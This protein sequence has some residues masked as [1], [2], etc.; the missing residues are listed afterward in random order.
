MNL[1]VLDTT[2]REGL[3]RVGTRLEP[4]VRRWVAEELVASG[5]AELEIGVVGRDGFL[6]A[7]LAGLQH[8]HPDHKIWVWTRMRP[9]DLKDARAMGAKRVSMCAPVSD[10]HLG[11]R[12]GWT[13][14]Q[15][16]ETIRAQVAY[17]I[18]LGL[19]VSVGLEDASRASLDDVVAAATVARDSGAK[20]VRFA[21]TVGIL[22]PSECRQAISKLVE[23]GLEV[24]FHGHDD[25]GLATANA[26]A[27]LEAGATAVDASLLG[28]GERAG[29]TSTER[30]AGFHSVRHG[31]PVDLGRLCDC[32]REIADRCGIAIP[33]HAPVV[34]SQ[35]F[36]CESGL[37]VAALAVAPSL[38]EP[39]APELVGSKRALLVGAQSGA[40]SVQRVL[41]VLSPALKSSPGLVSRVRRIAARLGRPLDSRELVKV[42]ASD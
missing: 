19:E 7:L 18:S 11:Q 16:L 32:A 15:L 35:I 14:D 9:D 36:R 4:R 27:A 5:I 22:S 17:A 37:H 21:D 31:H 38:Y 29:I 42:A 3:Q 10:Q 26:L 20:R 24:G 25:F 23:L 33:T 1:A 40:Q 12:L 30:L 34:G 28:W 39:Y 2:L 8:R 13:R 6:P 41:D